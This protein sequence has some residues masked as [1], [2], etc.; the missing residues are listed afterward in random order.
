[1]TCSLSNNVL[2]RRSQRG[3]QE[4]QQQEQT[5][6]T[7]SLSNNVLNRRSQRGNQEQQ[8][9]EQMD[10][11]IEDQEW[12]ELPQEE[13][14]NIIRA[15]IC[16][17]IDKEQREKKD[18]Q[19]D[20]CVIC[21]HQMDGEG[22]PECSKVTL[23]QHIDQNGR[24][25]CGHAFCLNCLCKLIKMQPVCPMCRTTINESFIKKIKNKTPLE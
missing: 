25:V 1:R 21:M 10:K 8:Q 12:L 7:C 22:E 20:Y 11:R 24:M 2:N 3:N 9:Q 6:R 4:Q 13:R 16:S 14:L 19:E 15:I 5:A 17:E 23:P 18:Q